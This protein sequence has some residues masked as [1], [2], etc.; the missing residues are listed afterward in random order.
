MKIIIKCNVFL[1]MRKYYL[2]KVLLTYNIVENNILHQRA[3]YDGVWNRLVC[4][5]SLE[6]LDLGKL[7]VKNT[8]G[9]V[10]EVQKR[11]RGDR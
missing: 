5:S 6:K 3:Q 1:L 11:S 2:S 10:T 9:K 7:R 4:V 8:P